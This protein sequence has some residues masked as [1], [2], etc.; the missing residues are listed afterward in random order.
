MAW[1][2]KPIIA[3]HCTRGIS[4]LPPPICVVAIELISARQHPVLQ[5]CLRHLVHVALE[6]EKNVVGEAAALSFCSRSETCQRYRR[7]IREVH[8]LPQC[9]KSRDRHGKESVLG[10]RSHGLVIFGA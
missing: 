9:G 10:R 1:P 7:K 3:R 6:L 4:S 2:L 8:W 5:T